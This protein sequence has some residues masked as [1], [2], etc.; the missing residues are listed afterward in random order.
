[1]KL[2]AVRLSAGDSA[3]PTFDLMTHLLA[4]RYGQSPEQVRAWAADD[5]GAAAALYSYTGKRD[6]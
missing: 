3:R 5:W 4:I 2:A 6:G 1:M